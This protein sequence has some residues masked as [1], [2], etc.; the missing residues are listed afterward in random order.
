MPVVKVRA[1]NKDQ[2]FNVT[3]SG[4]IKS[5]TTKEVFQASKDKLSA[6]PIIKD[7]E[8]KT[9]SSVTIKKKKK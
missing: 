5:R 7:K 8:K 2:F 3:S 6:T 9:F 4:K 1:D